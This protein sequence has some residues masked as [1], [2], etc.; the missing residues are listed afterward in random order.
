[1][2]KINIVIKK[3][4]L[5]RDADLQ[6]FTFERFQSKLVLEQYFNNS[7]FI[8]LIINSGYV[9][10]CVNHTEYNL[11]T[12]E[13]L[14]IPVRTSCEIVLISETLDISLLSFTPGFIF[15]N[16]IR[17]PNV[18]FFEFFITKSPWKTDLK[19]E[20][21]LLLNDL[22]ALMENKG[23][24]TSEYLFYNEVLSLTFNLLL[25]VLAS[26]YSKDSFDVKQ[27]HTRKEKLVFQFLQL[28][29]FHCAKE[30]SVKFYA[31]ALLITKGHLS[32][33]MQQ[34]TGKTVKQFIEEALILEAKILLQNDDLTIL[35]IIEELHFS[36]YSS[37][38]NFFRKST[39]MS[40]SEYRL[41]LRSE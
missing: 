37:F 20:D 34:V 21:F 9:K 35:Q 10:L 14:V 36:N 32:K 6:V 5:Y 25:Y 23:Y 18:G 29:E 27:K 28:L 17:K 38:S 19:N 2:G 12:N 40:P 33:T 8:I 41:K 16:T 31:D 24:R 22:F 4:L 30:H 3:S 13:L 39:F 15:N 26:L 7:Y 11:D 1:M